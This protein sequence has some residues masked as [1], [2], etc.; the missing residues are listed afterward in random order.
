MSLSLEVDN[1]DTQASDIRPV[2]LD[3]RPGKQYA[4]LF[5]AGNFDIDL[6]RF[7]KNHLID[8]FHQNF[9]FFFLLTDNGKSLCKSP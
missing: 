3:I 7:E 6:P 4:L 9:R 1:H 5:R 2:L 8:M